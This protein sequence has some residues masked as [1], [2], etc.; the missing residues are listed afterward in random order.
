MSLMIFSIGCG[1]QTPDSFRPPSSNQSQNHFG[2][3]LQSDPAY[4]PLQDLAIVPRD[5]RIRLVFSDPL[6]LASGFEFQYQLL[7]S[8]GE[9]IG[10]E[11][12]V[13]SR[14]IDHPE[15]PSR[16]VT[17]V[18]IEFPD[19]LLMPG[20]T[21]TLTWAGHGSSF[22]NTNPD[23][24]RELLGLQTVREIPVR[25]GSIRFRVGDEFLFP[26]T[27]G[28]RVLGC[29]PGQV[30]DFKN[31][32]DFFGNL[33]NNLSPFSSR[34]SLVINKR[35]PIR[36]DFSDRI[37]RIQGIDPTAFDVSD[38]N[39]PDFKNKSLSQFP[40]MVVGVLDQ[41]T[42]LSALFSDAQTS[43]DSSGQLNLQN[44]HLIYN[45]RIQGKVSSESNRRTLVFQPSQDYP[46]GLGKMI[47]YMI[48]NLRALT[49]K[50]DLAEPV[51]IGGFIHS[52]GLSTRV[53]FL[54]DF[55]E[56]LLGGASEEGQ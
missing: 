20:L 43:T 4:D 34:S 7:T 42:N 13:S 8:S 26:K 44:A 18:T 50:E 41:N 30:L 21:Y 29:S 56:D 1:N 15:D 3:L 40:G 46:E 12:I 32:S 24:N 16:K 55:I 25:A 39:L 17:E 47:I 33:A 49:T 19:R 11:K 52:S 27:G 37:D 53:N 9:H 54:N 31:N 48:G 2:R 5:P 45:N 14:L 38:E 28:F 6:D 23:I 22:Q 10:G 35:A 36:C 51:Y